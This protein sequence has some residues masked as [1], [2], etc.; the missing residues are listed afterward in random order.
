[1][2][3]N[4]NEA[5]DNNN[6][7]DG[8]LADDM[9]KYLLFKIGEEEYAL[10]VLSVQEI[11][12]VRTLTP[13]PGSTDYMV[14]LINLRGNILHVLDLRKRLYINREEHGSFDDDVIIVLSTDIRKF[15][16]LADVVTDVANVHND[17]IYDTPIESTH[18]LKITNVIKVDSR[19]IMILPIDKVVVS[20]NDIN[21]DKLNT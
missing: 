13:V 17:Q 14:G 20:D 21:R 15:G 8:T 16:V 12:G 1:M 2:T 5:F 4:K 10:D 9:S 3:D 19:V 6:L 18:G 11:V 7:G